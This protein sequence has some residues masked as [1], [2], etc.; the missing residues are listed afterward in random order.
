MKNIRL[1]QSS[2]KTV[3][4]L[5]KKTI[6]F[7]KLKDNIVDVKEKT[8]EDTI[9]EYSNKKVESAIN[10]T[11][12]Y[13]I[14]KSNDI[15]NKAVVE[16]GNNFIR[17]RS[18]TKKLKEKQLLRKKLQKDKKLTRNTKRKVKASKKIVKESVGL[19]KKIINS[20]K[21]KARLFKTVTK[22][23]A[24]AV[25]IVFNSVKA[26]VSAIIAGGWLVVVIIIFICIIGFLF[27][28]VYGIFFSSENTG[29]KTMSSVIVEINNEL[30]DKISNIQNENIHDDYVLNLK[31]PEWK[32]ILSV[33]SV[34]ISS[35]KNDRDVMTIT[36]EK[37]V[38]LKEIFWRM[39]EL[40]YY[41]TDELDSDGNIKK[42]L[43]ININSKTVGE[44]I[45]EYAL[46]NEQQ[47][48]LNE[49]LDDKYQGLWSNVV[50]GNSTGNSNVVEVALSQVGIKGGEPYWKWY[51]FN[52]RVEW[53]AIFVS[54]VYN[55]VGRLNT[56]VPRFSTCHTQGV[57]WFKTLGLWKDKGY[58]PNP[59]DIIFF[60]WEQDGHADHVGIVESSDG[61]AVYTV[62]GNSRDE[63][64][65]KKYDIDSKY[66]YGYGIPKH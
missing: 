47:K 65:Q 13:I 41:V 25:K 66:I 7:N 39:N 63:V 56:E 48:Q 4:K 45:N 52:S 44:M 34:I 33:Y 35:G 62:E 9:N 12:P 24:K 36:E 27:N 32:D 10:N 57:P 43:Y 30:A 18:M 51:G 28:S 21:R 17:I 42:I 14:K 60:D 46:N 31:R 20:A 37:T 59:G 16:T 55:E 8:N 11:Y 23:V 64:K 5:D 38:I 54:W 26:I 58:V 50:Y 49:L 22:A 53:C 40:S 29:D 61:R 2:K 15:G 6:G 1:R 3:K 19:P